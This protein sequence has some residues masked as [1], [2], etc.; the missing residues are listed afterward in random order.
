VY[1]LTPPRLATTAARAGEI[2]G[3]TLARLASVEV[4]ALIL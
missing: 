4:D 2:A 1:G 3:A